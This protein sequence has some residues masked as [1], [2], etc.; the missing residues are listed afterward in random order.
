MIIKKLLL[1]TSIAAVAALSSAGAYAQTKAAGSGPNPFSDCGIGAALFSET[2]WA[3]VTSNVIWDVGTTAVISATASPETCSGKRV[4]AAVFVNNT[5]AKL[6][7]ETAAGRGEH[8][9]TVLNILECNGARHDNA[10]KG[11]RVAMKEAIADPKY[12]DKSAL[13]K[14]SNFYSIIDNAVNN[15]CS[16]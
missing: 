3:A 2:K 8:L 14:A 9:T 6:S 16:V 4:V 10:I 7:E 11:I 1:S 12:V 13:E 15:S 5:Y